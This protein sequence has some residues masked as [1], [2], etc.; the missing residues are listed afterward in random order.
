M[1][2]TFNEGVIFIISIILLVL[3]PWLLTRESIWPC[4]SFIETGQIGDTIGGTTAPVIGIISICLLYKT[5]K[6]Q[7]DF[8]AKQTLIAHDE[9][10][11][12]TL[13]ALLQEQR[14]I[15]EK[16]QAKFVVLNNQDVTNTKVENVTGLSFF[17]QA[18]LQL[19]N[20]H[21]SLNAGAYLGG[22]DEEE[23][24]LLEQD[25]Y[26]E[27]NESPYKNGYPKEDY[28]ML[29][30]NI[31]DKRK[32]MLTKFTNDQYKITDSIYKK[33]KSLP[34][35]NQI[36]LLYY[37]FYNRYECV[38]YYFRH[39]YHILC[40]IKEAENK[41]KESKQVVHEKYKQY[42]Q[43]I[44]AQMST[45]ELFLLYYNSFVFP[46]MQKLL[47]DYNLLENLTVNNLIDKSHNC[48]FG[49]HLKSK[50]EVFAYVLGY[51][52]ANSSKWRVPS[53]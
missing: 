5:L 19:I 16:I 23:A 43:F 38:G 44:Q 7:Q 37:L 53:E 21:D 28:Q 14:D 33:H 17:R 51:D 29:C 26:Q 25:I 46:K 41:E 27:M 42:A 35:E 2:R 50:V 3:T 15:L 10:F 31:R 4:M 47:I 30:N 6:E 36:A 34:I 49:I 24:G 32:D 20:I 22:Y 45:D 40:F 8:S 1:K 11:K 12:S 18:R 13:F 9:Q 52:D 48:V 39:L